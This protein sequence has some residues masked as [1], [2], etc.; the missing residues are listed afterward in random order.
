LDTSDTKR[1]Q[2]LDTA[3]RLFAA[4]R[5]HEVKLDAIAAKAR[6]GK[7]TIYLYFKS[8]EDLYAAL[9]IDGLEMLLRALGVRAERRA[10][11]SAWA[12]IEGIVDALL[13]FARR[14][15]HLYTLLRSGGMI[16]DER[17]TELRAGLTKHC[18]R[19][20]RRGV[21]S[22]EFADPHPALTAQYLLS[23]VRVAL[24]YAPKGIKDTTL[25]GHILRVLGDGIRRP[26]CSSAEELRHERK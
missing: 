4:K 17:L 16:D 9:I 2:I 11:G 7:G 22:G 14:N 10:G 20:L 6:L 3:A 13:G 25:R 8:K 12:E 1:R 19:A 26:G 24:L 15:P 21:R 23:F 5:F 18:E